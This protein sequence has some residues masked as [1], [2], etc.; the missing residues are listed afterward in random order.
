[1]AQAC[2]RA[3]RDPAEVTIVAASKTVRAN[4]LVP[5][6]DGG[7]LVYGENRVQEAKDKWPALRSRF[8]AAQLHLL[9]P[10]QSNKARDAVALFDSI[11]SL[12]RLSLARALARA[13]EAKGRQP[14]LFVQ[15]NVGGE[16][17]KSGVSPEDVD[18]FLA[19]CG[20][21]YGL[22]VSGLMC[23]PPAAED[24]RLHFVRL[25]RIAADHG[26]ADLSMGMSADYGTAIECGAT[27]VRVGSEIFGARPRPA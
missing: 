5:F 2:A 7:M 12:D 8:P 22:A 13:V 20:Q 15:V 17:Q 1:M 11:H 16:A 10:L 4:E 18:S 6:L 25:G 24:P 9:G 14:Q 3:G 26:L 19:A 23:I 21:D 27:H